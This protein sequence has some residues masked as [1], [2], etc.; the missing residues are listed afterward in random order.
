MESTTT[1]T[2]N[3]MISPE[4]AELAAAAEEEEEE[5]RGI[6]NSLKKGRT[7]EIFNSFELFYHLSTYSLNFSFLDKK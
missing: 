6:C 2:P 4:T 3:S 5:D 1:L 7:I